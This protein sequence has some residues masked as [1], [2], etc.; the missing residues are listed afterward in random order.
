MGFK[1]P[2]KVY[3]LDFTGVE[4]LDGLLVEVGG[5]S[6]GRLMEMMKL[7]GIA[8]KSPEAAGKLIDWFTEALVSW[9]L[10]DDDDQGLG[11]RRGRGG[12]GAGKRL[13]LWAEVPGGQLADGTSVVKPPELAEAELIIRGCEMFSC[14]PAVFREQDGEILR[15]MMI[16]FRGNPQKEEGSD[17]D[18]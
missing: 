3:K 11:E 7:I 16:Y 10:E 4:D 17:T 18:G 6:T 5:L 13:D 14:T 9:N 1:A 12:G 2:K 8:D 15:L